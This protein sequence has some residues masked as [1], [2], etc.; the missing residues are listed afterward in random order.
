MI[1]SFIPGCSNCERTLW[2]HTECP[3]LRKIRRSGTLVAITFTAEIRGRKLRTPIAEKNRMFI[4]VACALLLFT[5][6]T[7][8]ADEGMWTFQNF[9]KA[10]VQQA[11]GVE[12]DDPWLNRVQRSITRHESGCTG[13][14]V[15][16]DGLVLTNHHCVMECL[17]ELSSE[18]NDYIANGFNSGT[19]SGERKC[20]TEM[21]SVLVEVEDITA[22]VNAATAASAPPARYTRR[23]SIRSVSEVQSDTAPT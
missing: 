19:R 16:P 9:P 12:I 13:S 20:P 3:R 11:Y 21:L 8:R 10:K 22:K 17:A 14:F 5:C 2:L 7:A 15:S 6:M 1:L 18:G 23:P 4:R